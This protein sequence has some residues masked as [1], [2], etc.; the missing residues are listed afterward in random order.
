MHMATKADQREQ[1]LRARRALSPGERR[2]RSVTICERLQRLLWEKRGGIL[3]SYLATE[4]E[5]DLSYLRGFTLAYPVCEKGG[6][7]EAVIPGAEDPL[8]PGLLGVRSPDPDRGRV[9]EPAELTAILAPCVGFDESCRRL[10]HGGGY[11]DRYAARCPDALLIC[12][13]FEAQKLGRVLTEDHDI[14]ADIVVTEAG[15]YRP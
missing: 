8:A 4:D 10:G 6:R 7:M 14:P 13:A 9:V 1:A 5:A 3:L 15:V 2:R 11:Y 12:A